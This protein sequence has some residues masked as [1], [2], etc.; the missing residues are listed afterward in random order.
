MATKLAVYNRALRHLGAIR[1]DPTLGLSENRPDRRELDAAWDGTVQEMLEQ[2]VWKFAVRTFAA[3]ADPNIVPAFGSRYGYDMPDDFVRFH[4]ICTDEDLINEDT[5]YEREGP[6]RIFSVNQTLYLSIVSKDPAYGLN[7]GAYTEVYATA[8][9]CLLASNAC[10][11]IT[12]D[13]NLQTKLLKTFETLLLPR[14]KR[15]DAIDER[16]KT[17]PTGTWVRSRF[18]SGRNTYRGRIS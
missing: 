16:V 17:K 10:V 12:K 18:I 8:L 5:S 7:I 11:A 13:Q 14:A 9:A 1:L 4:K 3:D 15:K 6:S 2:A